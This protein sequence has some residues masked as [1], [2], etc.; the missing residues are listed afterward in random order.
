MPYQHSLYSTACTA[1]LAQRE[2][3]VGSTL[4]QLHARMQDIHSGDGLRNPIARLYSTNA[5]EPWHVDDAD[6]V[7]EHSM[8]QHG[9]PSHSTAQHSMAQHST[10]WHSMA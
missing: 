1:Q 8:A 5:A 2:N 10:A 6:V 9:T 3:H 4:T 7:G